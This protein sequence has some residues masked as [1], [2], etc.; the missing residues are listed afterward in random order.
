MDEQV[1]LAGDMANWPKNVPGRPT[2]AAVLGVYHPKTGSRF[3]LR[4][5]G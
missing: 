4:M 1:E 3:E 2:Q 5:P